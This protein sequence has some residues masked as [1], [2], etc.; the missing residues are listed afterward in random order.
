V[1]T[2]G[3]RRGR[4]RS[5]RRRRRRNRC[6]ALRPLSR[7]IP[8][9]HLTPLF[10]LTIRLRYNIWTGRNICAR[11]NGKRS[12]LFPDRHQQND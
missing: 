12:T 8:D 9:V 1:T 6:A 10:R 5:D 7:R 3:R 4:K 2:E 11:S